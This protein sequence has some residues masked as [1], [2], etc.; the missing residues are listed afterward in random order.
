MISLDHPP[1]RCV[2]I[3][4]F[5][6]VVCAWCF[7]LTSD[8]TCQ[9]QGII[10]ALLLSLPSGHTLGVASGEVDYSPRVILVEFDPCC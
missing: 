4:V 5:V 8:S 2:C 7:S 3:G 10:P 1:G 6:F 9:Q